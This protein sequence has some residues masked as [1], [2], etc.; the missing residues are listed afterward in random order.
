[1]QLY[2]LRH[3]QSESNARWAE[4][5]GESFHYPDP[6]L[7]ALGKRQASAAARTLAKGKP[8]LHANPHDP[9]NRT[10]F[11]ITHIYTSLMLR[12][13]ETA[14]RIAARLDLAP[15]GHTR[16]HEWG[17]IYAWGGDG[18]EREG[19]PGKDRAFFEAHFPIMRLP[20]DFKDAGWWDRPHEPRSDVP[21]RAR[22]VFRELLGRHRNTS[23]RVLVVSHGGFLNFLL[24]HI[25]N[26]TPEQAQA[27]L[28]A[29]FWF[30]F[31]NTGLTRIDIGP[32]F[33]GVVYHNRTDHLTARMV[34]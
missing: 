7:T 2:L 21:A 9:W 27:N 8:D 32:V 19:L 17:G 18:E 5:P 3:G 33:C 28:D 20:D 12:A 23:D 34:T 15:Q 14:D 25:I 6:G 30:M 10:G 4:N 31:N 29:N 22:R 24:A 11:D 16:L 1:M 26:L 13:V